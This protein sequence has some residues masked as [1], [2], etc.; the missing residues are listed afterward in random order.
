[1]AGAT[2]KQR[3]HEA[4]HYSCKYGDL[5]RPDKC[6]ECGES[7]RR[8]E[9]HHEDYSEPLNIE[10]LCSSCHKSLH[11]R[12]N[13]RDRARRQLR[14]LPNYRAWRREVDHPVCGDSGGWSTSHHRPCKAKV[15][16]TGERCRAHTDQGENMV[17][18]VESREVEEG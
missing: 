4:V 15:D 7:G 8:I 11:V 6:P 10:W 14:R 12:Q 3:A 5:E 16:A 18:R 17:V 9:A 1:M 13:R 2:E